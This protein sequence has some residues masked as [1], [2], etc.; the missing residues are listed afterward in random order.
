M[1]H[2]QKTHLAVLAAFFT[3]MLLSACANDGG[4]GPSDYTPRTVTAC[5]SGDQVVASAS[6]CLQ[7][8]AACYALTNGSWCTGE[9]GNTCP[10]GSV[11]IPEGSTCPRGT[12]CFDVGESL[13]CGIP[14]S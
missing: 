4:S 13:T 12:R 9:R 2:S 14:L 8:G 7:D 3:A 11:A 1:I 5:R 6:Q 10:A